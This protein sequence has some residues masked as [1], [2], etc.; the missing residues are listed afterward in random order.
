MQL[1]IAK[2]SFKIHFKAFHFIIQSPKFFKKLILKKLRD[3]V[4]RGVCVSMK[5]KLDIIEGEIWL[6]PK[7]ELICFRTYFRTS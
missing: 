3:N 2:L 1:L 7:K 4:T 5:K 6:V